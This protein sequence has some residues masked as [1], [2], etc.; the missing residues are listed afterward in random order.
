MFIKR[1]DQNSNY[2]TVLFRTLKLILQLYLGVENLKIGVKIGLYL[3]MCQLDILL[4]ICGKIH[5][6]KV[7]GLF[8][9]FKYKGNSLLIILNVLI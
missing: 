3:S 2:L 8:Y 9:L 4:S 7:I 5:E 6:T 1:L